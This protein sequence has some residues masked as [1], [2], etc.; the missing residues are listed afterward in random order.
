MIQ[1]ISNKIKT[2][3]EALVDG[4]G[5][6]EIVVVYQYPE[7]KPLC[8]PYAIIDYKGDESVELT[9]YQDRV[10]HN[11][12][13]RLVQEKIEELKGRENAEATTMDRSYL[14]TSAFRASNDLDLSDVLIVKPVNVDK[15]YEDNN[16]RISLIINL[17]VETVATSST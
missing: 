6:S 3:L 11:F 10:T 5:S 4:E 16:T 8:Y 9:N 7:S 17:A 14:I 12:E 2:T 15:I 13:I 1:T